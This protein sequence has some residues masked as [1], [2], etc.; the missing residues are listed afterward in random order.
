MI[1]E[2]EG[3]VISPVDELLSVVISL[4][5]AFGFAISV[6]RASG[7]IVSVVDELAF[8]TFDSFRASGGKLES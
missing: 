1:F 8:E 3:V 2:W 5:G 4:G 6:D 7:I